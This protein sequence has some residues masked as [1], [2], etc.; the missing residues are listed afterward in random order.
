[1]RKI[2]KKFPRWQCITVSIGFEY[3]ERF[4]ILAV[5]SPARAPRV[6][7][8][9]NGPWGEIDSEIE[10]SSGI[11]FGIENNESHAQGHRDH[12]HHRLVRRDLDLPEIKV[13]FLSDNFVKFFLKNAD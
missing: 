7:A 12:N 11:D 4:S 8:I 10:I 13:T 2:E 9:L 6:L 3:F 1:M 5:S